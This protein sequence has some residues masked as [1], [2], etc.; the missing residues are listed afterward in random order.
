MRIQHNQNQNLR[1]NE[2][3]ARGVCLTCHGLGFALDA[4]A[5][6]ALIEKN[7]NGQ[8]KHQVRSLEMAEERNIASLKS[9][10]KRP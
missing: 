5:D 9:R 4:L 8:P 7:F 2:K 10:A 1:P 6:R 3:M